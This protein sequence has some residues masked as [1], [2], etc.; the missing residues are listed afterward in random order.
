[1]VVFPYCH[2]YICM[3]IYG[4][5]R[6]ELW[7]EMTLCSE[8][9]TLSTCDAER[10]GSEMRDEN[11]RPW[12]LFIPAPHMWPCLCVY[13]CHFQLHDRSRSTVFEV[14]LV[15]P[16]ISDPLPRSRK[17]TENVFPFWI[18]AGHSAIC[19]CDY[20]NSAPQNLCFHF[21]SLLWRERGRGSKQYH[22]FPGLWG[23]YR[24]LKEITPPFRLC[25]KLPD[26]LNV[27]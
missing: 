16:L 9:E 15:V 5:R 10:D 24:P 2:I 1:M 27:K 17:S 6:C 12:T 22:Y 3:Y 21:C 8:P 19:L 13:L 14:N 26:D 18:F 7:S 25:V 20:E 4:S 23:H 11:T